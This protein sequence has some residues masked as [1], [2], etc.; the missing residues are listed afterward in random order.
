MSGNSLTTASEDPLMK[1]CNKSVLSI[2]TILITLC[3]ATPS[4]ARGYAGGALG[5]Y[6]IDNEDFLEENNELRDNRSAWKVFIGGTVG[7]IF[8]LEA[9]HIDFG[10]S[11][12]GPLTLDTRGQTLAAT[13]GI[14]VGDNSRI[15]AKA[16]R[17]YW[18]A[19]AGIADNTLVDIDGDDPFYGAGIGFGV[20][21]GL[22][23]KVEYERYKL[24]DIDV[25]MPSVNL[26]LAF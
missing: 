18:D 6:R 3:V 19:D 8:G 4:L 15:Y 12:D 26:S 16:G 21:S 17:L 5:Y 24:G 2:V 23:V 20:T 25:D 13:L 7:E 9:A 14:P 22:G 10:D 1:N 11:R